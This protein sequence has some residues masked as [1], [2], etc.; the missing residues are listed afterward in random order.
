[1]RDFKPGQERIEPRINADPLMDESPRQS[2]RRS[3]AANED[4]ARTL[5]VEPRNEKNV[6]TESR[7]VKDVLLENPA[8]R[9]SA[10]DTPITRSE[11]ATRRERGY[12]K[13][14]RKVEKVVRMAIESPP[15]IKKAFLNGVSLG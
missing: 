11:S 15:G 6:P 12:E 2:R 8:P 10:G 4:V 3:Y 14:R 5:A 13:Y 9:Y 1:M 7:A